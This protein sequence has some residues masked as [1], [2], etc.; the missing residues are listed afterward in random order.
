MWNLELRSNHRPSACCRLAGASIKAKEVT[1]EHFELLRR[2]VS[3]VK[4]SD[5]YD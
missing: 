4:W 1:I 3:S 2:Q 5:A